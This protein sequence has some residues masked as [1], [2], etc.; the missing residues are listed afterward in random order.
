MVI[1]NMVQLIEYKP[2]LTG[3]RRLCFLLRE[4][5]PLV[6]VLRLLMRMISKK[7]ILL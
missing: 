5:E 3:K 6:E 7:Q 1:L 4:I 2:L